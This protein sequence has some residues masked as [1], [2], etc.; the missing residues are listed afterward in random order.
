MLGGT[1]MFVVKCTRE[2]DISRTVRGFRIKTD[3][4]GKEHTLFLICKN[5]T[6]IWVD[7][8]DYIPIE[9]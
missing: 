8:I 9:I 2:D 3:A 7:A 6:W 5:L 4:N 1:G